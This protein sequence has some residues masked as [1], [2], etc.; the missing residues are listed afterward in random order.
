VPKWQLFEKSWR[1]RLKIVPGKELFMKKTA[2]RVGFFSSINFKITAIFILLVAAATFL[3]GSLLI[4]QG[5]KALIDAILKKNL[6]ACENVRD[7]INN[8]IRQAQSSVEL[9]T[10]MPGIK[11]LDLS[12]I[13]KLVYEVVSEHEML[14]PVAVLNETG[15]VMASRNPQQQNKDLSQ[16]EAFLRSKSKS[17][18]SDVF[19]SKAGDPLITIASPILDRDNLKKR[20]GVLV[21]E[22]KLKSLW[23]TLGQTR[24]GADGVVVVTDKNG[25]LI[26]RT[27]GAKAGS[28]WQDEA[29]KS[30]LEGK[31]GSV[32][33]HNDLYAYV[34]LEGKIAG[35]VVIKQPAVEALYGVEKMKKQSFLL[36]AVSVLIAITIGLLLANSMLVPVKRLLLSTKIIGEGNLGHKINLRRNDEIGELAASFDKITTELEIQRKRAITDEL[37]HLYT[38]TYFLETLRAEIYRAK[39][40]RTRLSLMMLDID[41][42]KMFN[43]RYGHQ[44]GDEILVKMSEVIRG[45]LRESDVAARYGGEEFSILAAETDKEG[46]YALAE[47]LR[48]KISK[49]MFLEFQGK[50]M[51]VTVSIGV[52]TFTE[53]DIAQDI[54]P[55]DF[56][57]RADSALYQAKDRGKNCVVQF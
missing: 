15:V 29:V 2:Q 45:C 39:R 6:A 41:D 50:N 25:N 35:A 38:H 9:M 46:I 19:F 33:L 26:Y 24:A 37:T 36:L 42:F 54:F 20:I 40:Y 49:E 47:R 22:V 13:D 23:P 17:Y 18:L 52:T 30:A 1:K 8:F 10:L 43:D 4:Y 31:T 32:H 5:Q 56:L 11:N 27:G 51:K 21:A 28:L 7:K 16:T 48:E 44:A 53:S 34:P 12:Q 14:D 57:K 55:Q 3:S